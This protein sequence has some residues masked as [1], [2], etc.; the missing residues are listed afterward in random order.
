MKLES[1]SAGLAV[2]LCPAAEP[3]P[4]SG[5][6]RLVHATSI[7]RTINFGRH[8]IPTATVHSPSP[9]PIQTFQQCQPLRLRKIQFL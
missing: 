9:L 6:V 3:G 2:K 8:R 4:A 5:G 7:Q 1:L